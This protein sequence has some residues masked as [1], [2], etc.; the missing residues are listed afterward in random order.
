MSNPSATR[1]IPPGTLCH[2]AGR[3]TRS[4]PDFRTGQLWHHTYRVQSADGGRWISG[5]R[6]ADLVTLTAGEMR[7]ARPGVGCFGG[8]EAR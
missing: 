4:Y 2:Y 6:R 5:I 1:L 7:S 8:C 3:V